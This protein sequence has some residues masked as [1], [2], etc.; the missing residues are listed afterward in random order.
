MSPKDT[1]R[2]L[3][4]IVAVFAMLFAFSV[5]AAPAGAHA[6]PVED[7]SVTLRAEA[8][9]S[10]AGRLVVRLRGPKRRGCRDSGRRLRSS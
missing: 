10:G 2:V 6:S 1:G 5:M 7:P 9:A 8:V 4:A 3:T